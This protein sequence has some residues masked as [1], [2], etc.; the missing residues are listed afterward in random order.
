[1][2]FA[3]TEAEGWLARVYLHRAM[4]NNQQIPDHHKQPEGEAKAQQVLDLI[5]QYVPYDFQ[6]GANWEF[7]LD[8]WMHMPRSST[9]TQAI[10][11]IAEIQAARE[12]Y[13]NVIH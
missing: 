2:T 5:E 1:M 7:L 4:V 10:A 6:S 9:R 3:E 8:N 12:T 11:I 13:F